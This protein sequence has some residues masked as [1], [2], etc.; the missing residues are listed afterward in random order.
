MI[1]DSQSSELTM[2]TEPDFEA[3]DVM[4]EKADADK[5]IKTLF[6]ERDQY[7]SA[8]LQQRNEFNDIY[9]VYMGQMDGVKKVPY[10]S[11]ESSSK[12]RTEIAYVVPS[13]YSGQPEI[14][15]EGVG[16]E[17]KAIS[18][19]IEKIINYRFQTIPQFNEKIES[20]VKQSV[21]FGTS[22]LKVC[23]KFETEEKTEPAQESEDGMEE[24]NMP[25]TYKIVVKDEPDLEIPNILDCYYNPVLSEVCNQ[26]SLIFR[27][28]L[29]L[30]EVKENPLYDFVGVDGT[31]N[32]AKVEGKGAHQANPY[33]SSN[34]EQSDL[35]DLQK[36]GEGTVEIFER[37]TRDRIQTVVDG[38]ERLVLRDTEWSYGYIPTVKL[39]HEPNCI[40]N[41]FEGLGVGQN[42]MGIGKLYY[43][44]WNQ[45]IDGV[46]L[47]NNPMFFFKKGAGIDPRQLV[48]KPG[49]GIAVEGEKPL[50]EYIQ[51]VQ[52]PDTKQGATNLI[53]KLEDEHRRA[54]GANDLVQGAA[55]NK[56]LGQ[57]QIAS[58]YSS[59][60]FELIQRRFKQALADVA[61]IIIKM[62]LKNLQSPDAEIL[63]IF[64]EELRMDIYQLL[65]NGAQNIK[66][67]IRVKGET[68]VAKNK[69]I[70][71][72]QLIDAYNLFGAILPPENQIEWARK[73]LELRGIDEL[74]KLVPSAEQMAQKQAEMQQQAM[75][76][77]GAIDPQM[78]GQGMPQQPSAMM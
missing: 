46:T 17:D 48:A 55:S 20:W 12:L 57:D 2:K 71:I 30:D 44:M 70:Q 6:S 42:T 24:E 65:I 64:P 21:T 10:K 28:V 1:N 54:S 34:Q 25:N 51:A 14:E 31:P 60:R 27:S 59:Q 68:N 36:A 45:T 22:L 78:M 63:R 18:K 66:F 40:P 23:W 19:V 73:I 38:K 26:N 5:I 7:Q 49:G 67:N 75:M 4:K 9:K 35:I 43:K 37:I 32:R 52:F 39:T 77:Q 3:K 11:K 56:T 72:K 15:V 47:T 50:A 61:E 53:D 13:I 74:D 33:D 62:E 16:E 58:T 76:E 8:N 41:R 69:D 29:T